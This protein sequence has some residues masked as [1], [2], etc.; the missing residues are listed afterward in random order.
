VAPAGSGGITIDDCEIE[1]TDASLYRSIYL[2]NVTAGSAMRGNF[3]ENSL[4]QVDNSV[5]VGI[6]NPDG[7]STAEYVVTNSDLVDVR[8]TNGAS[9]SADN[10]N[11]VVRVSASSFPV[12]GYSNTA[13]QPYTSGVRTTGSVLVPDH[14]GGAN[15]LSASRVANQSM[16]AA[17]RT[18]VTLPSAL[19]D[20]FSQWNSG[21]GT[22][23]AAAAGRYLI[24]F[25]ATF[26][27]STAGQFF[28][29]EVWKNGSLNSQYV[30]CPGTGGQTGGSMQALLD[31]AT[32]D[33]VQIQVYNSDA[34]AYNLNPGLLTITPV[35]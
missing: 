19:D 31:L 29:L 4:V 24:S 13:L 3:V 20:P 21:T 33:T 16:G 1:G 12:G 27:G 35:T 32:N 28:Q 15:Y 25:G 5:I 30:S 10:T 8:A 2:K 11:T 9:F 34:A 6:E 14:N 17:G 26:D 18:V 22:F 7:G 23:T